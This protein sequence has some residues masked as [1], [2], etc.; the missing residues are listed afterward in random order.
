MLATSCRLS[1]I[2]SH[3]LREGGGGGGGGEGGS[4]GG[5]GGGRE[6]EK[7]CKFS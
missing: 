4:E 1:A 3:T 6:S 7:A 2:F 5:G